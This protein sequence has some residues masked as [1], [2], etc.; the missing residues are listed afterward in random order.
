VVKG[1]VRGKKKVYAFL[2]LLFVCA[3][4][5]V[6]QTR[7]VISLNEAWEFTK[8]DF[9]PGAGDASSASWESIQL[10]HTWNATDVNDDKPGYY[11]GPAWYRKRLVLPSSARNKPVYLRFEGANQLTTVYVNG[12]KAA[13]H[14]GGY[15]AFQ[16]PVSSFLQFDEEQP[17]EI[18][19]RV[20]NSH[21]L[22]VPPL[23]AD[24]TFF[25][26]IYRDAWLMTLS[27]VHFSLKDHGSTGI[28]I[29]TPSVNAEKAHVHIRGTVSNEQNKARTVQVTTAIFNREGL[30]VQQVQTSLLLKPGT[31]TSFSQEIPSFNKPRLWS[32][33]DPYLYTVK[34]YISESS[35][36][37]LDEVTNPLGFRWFHFGAAKGFFLN[38]RSYKL[39]GASR[40]QDRPGL[41]NAL[42]D[43]LARQDIAW[44][45]KMGG[46]FLRVAHYPQDPS[47]LEACDRMGILASVEIPVVNEITE[48]DSFYTQ[49]E[50]M[51]VEMVRQHFNHPSVIL[52]CYMN[53]VLLR[54]H[55][56]ND[57]PRQ[58]IY[59]S[60]IAKL[61]GRLDSLTRREDP[62]R[63][64]MIAHH[65]DFDRYRDAGLTHIPMVVGWNL[66]SGWY[67]AEM[68]G[69]PA[70]LDRH[71]KELPGKP[72]VVAEYGADA[73]PRIRSF[74]PVRFDKSVEYTNRFHQYYLQE[75]MKR[76]FVA[77][78]MIWNLADFNSETREETMPHINNKGLL[79]GDRKPKDPFYFYQ[80][81][82]TKEPFVKILASDWKIRSGIADSAARVCYQPVQV[83]GNL[84]SVELMVN[85]RSLGW[86]KPL[87]GVCEWRIPFMQGVNV[88]EAR[89]KKDG[90]WYADHASVQ[91][92]MQPYHLKDSL[93][94]FEEVNILLGANRYFTD[95]K[96][97]QVWIPDQ[98]YRAGSWGHTG[99][100]AFKLKNNGRL[101]YGTDK[102]IMGTDNDPVY[103][104]QQTGI[105][106][107]RLDVPAGEY[108][109]TLHFAE[110]QNGSGKD[111]PYN[112][113][114]PHPPRPSPERR[115]HV[116]AN[117]KLLLE[118]FNIAAQYG[119]ARAVSKKMMLSVAPGEGIQLRFVPLA[120][121]PVLNALQVRKV[122]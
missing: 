50:S 70:F 96:T 87:Q 8:D 46:N 121:E 26:G 59:F 77:G 2:L 40:H 39:V 45:K 112:L 76:P 31:E 23:S 38:G 110:L 102:D 78:A 100:H 118:D 71:H 86:K 60:N 89:S 34:T 98:A 13:H 64:T 49:C 32:P 29:T 101:P 92:I 44:L 58:K 33:E 18:L 14:A 3:Q 6:S 122:Y 120:G 4:A 65:G 28:F 30:Q 105:S 97:G 79:T 61:A 24:F 117:N 53:E 66:Y 36:Q 91:F 52:W 19:V 15:T 84:D 22:Q 21:N 109:V 43:E 17:N 85:G 73:D 67:G 81:M 94:P 113:S 99:G 62:Y 37:V 115:F 69:F 95:A 27:P 72:M 114:P 16:F 57:K 20:D 7:S 35:G 12:H 74:E 90:R 56:P 47:V 11:R 48:S 107:Y 103:Q 75:M 108:E 93:Q 68:E 5:A 88:I 42:P 119:S 63:Y 106:G 51:Q 116:Y 82:L 83:A 54:P 41:G 9:L 25:G 80:A 1:N 10:P 104:T 55:F 111:L